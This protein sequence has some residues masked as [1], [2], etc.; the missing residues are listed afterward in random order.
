MDPYPQGLR[1]SAFFDLER[2]AQRD[3]LTRPATM[4][5]ST[6]W[7]GLTVLSLLASLA[8]PP[9]F[10]SVMALAF[11]NAGGM[12]WVTHLNEAGRKRLR[13]F[14]SEFSVGHAS[15]ERGEYAAAAAHYESLAPRYDDHPKISQIARHRAAFLKAAHPE[16]FSDAAREGATTLSEAR[17][18]AATSD[19]GTGPAT[20]TDSPAAVLPQATLGG[21][22]LAPGRSA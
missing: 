12:L 21:R 6:E 8:F 22:R 14:E 19:P 1:H 18:A 20:V 15:E 16:A 2:D 9:Y 3:A 13:E 11:L 10:L 4:L 5:R 17:P 7:G